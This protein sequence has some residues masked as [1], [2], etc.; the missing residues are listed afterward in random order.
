MALAQ[1]EEIGLSKTVTVGKTY[2]VSVSDEF[3]LT[4]GKSVL[5]MKSDGTITINGHNLSVG[6]TG[7]Q[8]YQAD[9]NIVMNGKKI[10]G[11]G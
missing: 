3:S 9:G 10:L 2:H 6:T 1:A 5:V 11:N 8:N 4:V 7:E